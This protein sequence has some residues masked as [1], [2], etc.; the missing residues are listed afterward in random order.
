MGFPGGSVVRNPPPNA[1]DVGS[2]LG[3]GDVQKGMAICFSILAWKTPRTEESGGLPST[4]R[5]ELDMPE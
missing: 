5:K 2:T 3:Q 4:G 1:G